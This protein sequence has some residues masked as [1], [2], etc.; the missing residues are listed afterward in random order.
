MSHP[1]F[2]RPFLPAYI[3]R[4]NTIFFSPG[5]L[6]IPLPLPIVNDQ[7]ASHTQVS[8]L[9]DKFMV[10]DLRLG[11]KKTHETAYTLGIQKAGCVPGSL[12]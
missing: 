8:N 7:H 4:I 6:Q 11:V 12:L 5:E 9:K 3:K 10:N 1:A 2:L